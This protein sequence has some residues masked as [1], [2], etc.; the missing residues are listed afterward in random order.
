MF[1]RIARRIADWCGKPIAFILSIV[2]VVVWAA[3]GPIF[4][5]SD[6]HQLVINTGTTIVTFWLLFLV[7]NTQNRDTKAM[8]VKLDEIIRGVEKASNRLI[9]A[10]DMTDEELRTL[11]N[12][13]RDL[14]GK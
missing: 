9:A 8:Q 4:G 14:A 12:R 5:W 6:T 3:T 7:Q 11:R 2:V 10:E 1:D 13:Y